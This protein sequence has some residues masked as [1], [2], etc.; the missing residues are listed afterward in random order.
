M[1]TIV[2]Q[3]FLSMILLGL[4]SLTSVMA[5][6][7]SSVVKFKVKVRNNTTIEMGAT[8]SC[9]KRV[10]RAKNQK[11]NSRRLINKPITKS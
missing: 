6:T 1:K 7:T 8:G 4:I 5:Q 11:E 3:F 2:F 10:G 9:S